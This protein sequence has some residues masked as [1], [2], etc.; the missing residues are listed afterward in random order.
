VPGSPIGFGDKDRARKLLRDA[1]AL[2]PNGLD[3]NYFWGDYL[4]DTGETAAA[5][6]ALQKALRAPHDPARPAWDTG[7]R[8]EV[9]TLLAKLR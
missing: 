5:T 7:R 9:Q 2:D 4:S 8:R 6:A 3:A 1:L